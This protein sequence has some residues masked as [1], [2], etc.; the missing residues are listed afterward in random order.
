MPL[1]LLGR[2]ELGHEGCA[3]V[4][5]ALQQVQ[6][7]LEP[8]C[9]PFAPRRLTVLRCSASGRKVWIDTQ[10]SQLHDGMTVQGSRAGLEK[11]QASVDRGWYRELPAGEGSFRQLGTRMAW[12]SLGYRS[13]FLGLP[14]CWEPELRSPV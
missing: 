6:Q 7:P 14:L 5:G 9:C 13:A 11:T 3:A 8:H 4:R 12:V 1:P 10:L 2:P